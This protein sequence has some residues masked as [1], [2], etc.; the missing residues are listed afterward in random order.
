MNIYKLKNEKTKEETLL[1]DQ[2]LKQI[3]DNHYF[4]NHYQFAIS[5]EDNL[6]ILTK[7]DNNITYMNSSIALISLL[8]II[9]PKEDLTVCLGSGVSLFPWVINSIN[10]LGLNKISLKSDVEN[11]INI[12][13]DIENLLP[14]SIDELDLER[15]IIIP[16]GLVIKENFSKFPHVFDLSSETV[17]GIDTGAFIALNKIDFADKL[18]WMKSSY[19]R[20]G[21]NIDISVKGNGRF[22]EVQAAE[23]LSSINSQAI[24]SESLKF[25]NQNIEELIKEKAN[26]IFYSSNITT[27]F[28]EINGYGNR[29]LS[30]ESISSDIRFERFGD[31]YFIKLPFS[32]S[33][34]NELV[35]SF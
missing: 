35:S 7:L 15:T 25:F 27:G 5:L 10:Y 8:K 18:R 22:S 6:Q 17:F 33:L 32:I 2:M 14:V 21:E 24:Y 20:T 26:I 11:S 9:A 4:S 3:F 29:E 34:A 30:L 16:T 12:I 13:L 28:I 19:A 1:F 31:K 23:A